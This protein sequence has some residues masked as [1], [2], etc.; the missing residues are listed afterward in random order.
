MMDK[1]GQGL[2]L[3]TIIIA[4]IALIV[5]V[6]II[7]IFTGQLG[8]KFVPGLED[9]AEIPYTMRITY[10]DCQPTASEEQDFLTNIEAAGEDVSLEEQ[11]EVDFK[12]LIKECKD[13]SAEE[14]EGNTRCIWKG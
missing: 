1:K 4:A 3:T 8:G 11:A 14:C 6:I 10:G 5:L 13:N 9:T 2:S 12:G 7:A